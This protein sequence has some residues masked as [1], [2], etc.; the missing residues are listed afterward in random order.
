MGYGDLLRNPAAQVR[1]QD[2]Q[3]EM[4]DLNR[5]SMDQLRACT[6]TFQFVVFKTSMHC[7]PKLLPRRLYFQLRFFTFPEV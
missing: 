4:I 3:A 6:I 7:N 5:E 2:V 1:S